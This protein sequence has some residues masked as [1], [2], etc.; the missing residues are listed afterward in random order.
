[1]A[2][3]EVIYARVPE[4]LK[5]EAEAQ[6]EERGVTLTTAVVDLLERGLASLSDERSVAKLES[7][8]A[9]LSE[10]KTDVER[11]LDTARVALD[12][13]RAR[14]E[15]TL[16]T[17]PQCHMPITGYDVLVSS[18]CSNCGKGLLA[19]LFPAELASGLDMREFLPLLAAVGALVG[20]A[21]LATK[22]G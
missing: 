19:A 22:S 13:L 1:M 21:Y 10:E 9:K 15:Q 7:R 2:A 8:V 4:T 11:E 18:R 17:C 5:D 20:V 3:T 12:A 16:G 14:T 6:A